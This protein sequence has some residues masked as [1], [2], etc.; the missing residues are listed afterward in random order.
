MEV[1]N[2]ET[3]KV[4]QFKTLKDMNP[5]QP[6][7]NAI[8]KAIHSEDKRLR[9][10]YSWL[11][12]QNTIG[13][14]FFLGSVGTVAITAYA[15]L[16]GALAWYYMIPIIAIAVS[17]LHE[18]E[19]DIIHDLYFKEQKWVQHLM[20]S[21]IWITKMSANPWWRKPLHLKHHK[22][23]GQIVDIEE[24]LIGLGLPIG[25]KKLA[26]T[27]SPF[28]VYLVAFEISHDCKVRKSLPGFDVFK[29]SLVNLP[30]MIPAIASFILS[31]FPGYVPE[32]WYSI[33]FNLN[34]LFFLPNVLRQASLQTVSTGVH[35]FGDIPDKNVFF[36]NQV[37]NHWALYPLQLFCF[38]FG[39]TH[40]I[41][42]YVT[43]Q[44]FYLRQMIAPGVMDEFKRQG[45][46]FNDLGIWARAHSWQ[47]YT[48]DNIVS[49][50]ALGS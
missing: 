42:H 44:P 22:T 37:I 10:K 9:T 32:P 1:I 11:Q 40:I 2:R 15:Y 47:G 16:T 29:S 19:H 7:I 26:C 39:E 30:V 49:P 13:M 43:R 17:I 50:V 20:F 8:R 24:R 28:G 4:T 36:Q 45:V 31:F 14:A 33:C 27:L 3:E 48:G 25:W 34:M 23:S 21:V 41:H 12:H 6:R 46:R 18:M 38:N 35:Y 5:Y